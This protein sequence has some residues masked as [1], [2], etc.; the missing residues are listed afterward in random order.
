VL[1]KIADENGSRFWILNRNGA[2]VI[3]MSIAPIKG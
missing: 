2:G 3:S 1:N